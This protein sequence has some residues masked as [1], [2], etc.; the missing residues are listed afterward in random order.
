MLGGNL[1][2]FGRAIKKEVPLSPRERGCGPW[3]AEVLGAAGPGI[4]PH[5]GEPGRAAGSVPHRAA[6]TCIPLPRDQTLKIRMLCLLL[7]VQPCFALKSIACSFFFSSLVA[8]GS[9]GQV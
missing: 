2:Q 3:L 9:Q 5:S 6:G 8:Q 1:F 7:Y 4:H